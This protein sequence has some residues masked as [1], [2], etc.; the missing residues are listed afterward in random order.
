MPPVIIINPLD[1]DDEEHNHLPIQL[2]LVD[3][4]IVNKMEPLNDT[5][6][7]NFTDRSDLL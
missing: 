6:M 4:P 1:N 7:G 2:G 3:C 5:T